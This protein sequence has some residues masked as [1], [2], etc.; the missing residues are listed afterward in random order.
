MRL[1]HYKLLPLIDKRRICAQHKECCMF[2]GKRFQ[3]GKYPGC[4]KDITVSQLYNYHLL[5]MKEMEKR[6]IKY[7]HAWKDILYR[8]KDNE[9]WECCEFIPNELLDSFQDNFY[10]EMCRQTLESRGVFVNL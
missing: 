4:P 8:G 3:Y 5:V 1:W 10:L 2:R 9:K 6:G 7:D